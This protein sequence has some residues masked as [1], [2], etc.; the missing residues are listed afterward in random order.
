MK[1]TTKK[2]TKKYTEN[3]L[4]MKKAP[5]GALIFNNILTKREN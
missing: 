1:N 4:I 3:N 5:Y 2:H